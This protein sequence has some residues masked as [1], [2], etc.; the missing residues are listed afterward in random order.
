MLDDVKDFV[1]SFTERLSSPIFGSFAIS[2]LLINYEIPITLVFYKQEDLIRDGYPSFLHVIW[3]HSNLWKFGV[4]PL[5]CMFCYVIVYPWIRNGVSALH[6]MAD[7]WGGNVV[8]K[9]TKGQKVD[10]SKFIDLRDKMQNDRLRLDELYEQDAENLRVI[11]TLEADKTHL[12]GEITKLNNE[13]EHKKLQLSAGYFNGEFKVT[14]HTK[15][16]I[17]HEYLLLVRETTWI[18]R[19]IASQKVYQIIAGRPYISPIGEDNFTILFFQSSAELPVRNSPLEVKYIMFKV[20]VSDPLNDCE[21]HCDN[22]ATIKL[23]K[24]EQPLNL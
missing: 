8:L 24:I 11:K 18:F 1:K 14:L 12:G 15:N 16:G 6:A 4:L 22:D 5:I 9:A 2:W 23:M 10:I 13:I 7:A 20:P 21:G 19:E 3:Q 17:P